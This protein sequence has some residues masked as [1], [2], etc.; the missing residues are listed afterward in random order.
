MQGITEGIKK[1]I[2]GINGML[3][4]KLIGGIF[5]GG[6][7]L[8]QLII[9]TLQ[10]LIQGGVDQLTINDGAFSNLIFSKLGGFSKL[11]IFGSEGIL[12]KLI[13][14]GKLGTLIK[15]I[16]VKLGAS[17]K[18]THGNDGGLQKL[19]HGNDGA[20]VKLIIFGSEGTLQKL[21]H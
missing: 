19:M 9:G 17:Q 16:G 4:T 11:I 6:Q 2:G 14:L 13:H 20:F 21:I 12:Q 7:I 8:I 5:G 1:L 15:L 18:L 10:K 3:E